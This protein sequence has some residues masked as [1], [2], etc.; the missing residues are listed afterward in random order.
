MLNHN[1][2]RAE[3]NQRIEDKRRREAALPLALLTALEGSRLET[4]AVGPCL[5]YT[6]RER[7]GCSIWGSCERVAA[8]RG[9][10]RSVPLP[11]ISC[12]FIAQQRPPYKVYI[13]L[14][15]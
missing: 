2:S 5:E 12:G 14:Y 9:S 13:R 7:G 10:L 11:A 15:L 1:C 4:T 3:E 6:C 8:P